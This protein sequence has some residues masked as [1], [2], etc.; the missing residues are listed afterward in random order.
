MWIWLP[1]ALVEQVGAYLDADE[2]FRSILCVWTGW[3]ELTYIPIT[4]QASRE[5]SHALAART[6]L[7]RVL[8]V[9]F[10]P[11]PVLHDLKLR[12]T[13]LV[14]LQLTSLSNNT[15]F[16]LLEN[17]PTLRRC[18]FQF[19]EG[20]GAGKQHVQM[21]KALETIHLQNL[22]FAQKAWEDFTSQKLKFLD[23][24]TCQFWHKRN[25]CH[26]FGALITCPKLAH[27]NVFSYALCGGATGVALVDY[28]YEK[29]GSDLRS[30]LV[31]C[32]ALTSVVFS[33]NVD[34]AILS[35]YLQDN[36]RLRALDLVQTPSDATLA[37]IAASN[38]DWL[39]VRGLKK[40]QLPGLAACT[41]L[42][43]LRLYSLETLQ[44][45]G[46]LA[47]LSNLRKI[48]LLPSLRSERWQCPDEAVRAIS[49]LTNLV[50]VRLV[51]IL[52]SGQEETLFH[53]LPRLTALIVNRAGSVP[54]RVNR[55][56][57][58]FMVRDGE[59]A[60]E[61]ANDADFLKDTCAEEMY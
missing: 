45:I 33:V 22:Y 58:S 20:V 3:V 52:T 54:I 35:E 59:I 8:K 25:A 38:I 28:D 29:D 55:R 27:L 57:A 16:M 14:E 41:K 36:V 51:S 61:F 43:T 60:A 19:N 37:Q 11:L 44:D 48:V 53:S 4:L 46:Y 40:F 30:L 49:R 18:V 32:K 1:K 42:R 24:F 9:Q 23:L 6:N 5:A 12:L 26:L 50:A 21:L 2:F 47:A 56:G 31:Q 17:F 13:G 10:L 7:T 34:A 15:V 39:S